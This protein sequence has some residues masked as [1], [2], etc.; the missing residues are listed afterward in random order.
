MLREQN[1]ES[2]GSLW[3]LVALTDAEGCLSVSK[4]VVGPVK[5]KALS[6]KRSSRLFHFVFLQL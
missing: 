5:S 3:V 6:R 1:I 2:G 4:G